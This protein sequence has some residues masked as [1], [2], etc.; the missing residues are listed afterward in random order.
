MKVA[1]SALFIRSDIDEST[2][3]RGEP[4]AFRFKRLP[5]SKVRRYDTFYALSMRPLKLRS[6]NPSR[7]T[8]RRSTVRNSSIPNA[9]YES[10][11][12]S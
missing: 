8:L 4:C 7:P 9:L 11:M 10:T 12:R 2:K 6:S 5:E 3:N 1:N